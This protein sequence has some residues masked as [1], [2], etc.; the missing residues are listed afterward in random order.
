MAHFATISIGL[1]PLLNDQSLESRLSAENSGC[2]SPSKLAKEKLCDYFSRGQPSRASL[3]SATVTSSASLVSINF[4]SRA[5]GN[6]SNN[7]MANVEPSKQ[8]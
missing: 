1:L 2:E 4:T 8:G 3:E 6:C 5:Y 7:D